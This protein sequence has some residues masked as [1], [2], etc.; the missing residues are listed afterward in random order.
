MQQQQKTLFLSLVVAPLLLLAFLPPAQPQDCSP[1]QLDALGEEVTNCVLKH[2]TGF[3]DTQ[4]TFQGEIYIQ[5]K[6]LVQYDEA[7]KPVVICY[8]AQKG[9]S[10]PNEA[11]CSTVGSILDE[12]GSMYGSCYTDTE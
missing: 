12:C 1:A 7:S 11:A 6:G 10:G 5:T 2:Q 8:F 9:T 3:Q 4:D